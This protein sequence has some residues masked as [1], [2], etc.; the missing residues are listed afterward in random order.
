MAGT[1]A[2]PHILS[3][4]QYDTAKF[5]TGIVIPGIG[6]LYFA[7]AKIWNFPAGEEVLGSLLAF[8]AFLGALL[9]VSS[10]SYEDSGA[11]YTGEIN[12]S[13]TED[14]VVYSLDLTHDPEQLRTQQEAI[15]KVNNN[16]PVEAHRD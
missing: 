14:K 15:F 3:N 2:H 5:L 12:V 9:G 1:D 4:K 6:T 13:E 11:K 16:P 7:L 8:E 10:K